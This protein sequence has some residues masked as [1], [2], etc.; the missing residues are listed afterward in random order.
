MSKTS[1]V[2]A[3]ALGVWAF[4]AWRLGD[5]PLTNSMLMAIGVVATGFAVWYI[6]STH[7]IHPYI[8]RKKPRAGPPRRG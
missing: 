8:R 4:V 6:R 5:D 1:Y 3:L 7:T 2:A